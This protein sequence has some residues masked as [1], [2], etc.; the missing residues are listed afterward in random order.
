MTTT[1]PRRWLS[2]MT[3]TAGMV[4]LI[5]LAMFD[6]GGW[7]FVALLLVSVGGAVTFFHFA[8]PGGRFFMIA[9]ANSLAIYAC[10]FQAFLQANFREIGSPATEI[11][12]V[13]PIV[14]FLGGT[15]W[16]RDRIRSIVASD[17]LLD[18]THLGTAFGWLVPMVAI[19]AGTFVMAEFAP[20]PA[21]L[22]ALFLSAMALIAGIVLAVSPSV[23]TFLIDTGLLF[24]EF[25][26]RVNRMAVAVF[27]FITFYSVLIILFAALYRIIDMGGGGPHFLIAGAAR[28]LTFPESLY[29]SIITMA[30][31][32]YGDITPTTDLARIVA[33]IQVVLGI[34]LLLFGFSEIMTYT[35]ERRSDRG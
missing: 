25:F 32:G 15:W 22:E 26:G 10:V 27:A 7:A 30:T 23:S 35:R 13:L 4:G 6:V 24:E 21:V 5:A 1:S 31:V 9:L 8:F 16:R 3:F 18:R 2:A 29:F 33:S 11:G 17:T 12:F 34:L 28:A 20:S 14:A 19:G